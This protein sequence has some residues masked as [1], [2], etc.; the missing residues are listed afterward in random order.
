M[1]FNIGAAPGF[2]VEEDVAEGGSRCGG[3]SFA[4]RQEVE[5]DERATEDG[6]C[7]DF[8]EINE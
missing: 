7:N 8:L 6:C 5:M 3:G 4:R 2:W 1:S